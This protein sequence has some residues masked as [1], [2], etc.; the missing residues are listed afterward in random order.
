MNIQKQPFGVARNNTPVDLF[1]LTNDN[2]ITV[3][4]TNYGGIIT[5]I[6]TPDRNG[7]PGDIVLGFDKLVG[8]LGPHP[9]FGALVG[10]NAN[11]TA[12]ARF[13]LDD[14]EY[15]LAQN[16]GPNH[17]HGGLIGFDKV[18]W[19]AAEFA[20]DVGVGVVLTYTS[21]DGEEGYPGNLAAQVTYTLNNQNEL[22]VD[23]AATTDAP[24]VVN[25]TNHSY[26]NLAGSGTILDHVVT[27]NANRYTPVDA[28]LIP[29]GELAPVEGTPMDFRQ[30]TRI[31]E[32]IDQPHEQLQRGG[33][34]DHNW[35]LN[36]LAGEMRHAAT[37]SEPTSGRRM[38]VSTTQPGI[39]FYCGNMMPEQITGKGG[40]VYPRRGGLCLETQNFPDAVNQPTFP[41]PVLRPGERYAQSTLFRFGR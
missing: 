11:R 35:V 25:L 19:Q 20:D 31:G 34:Y 16:N 38:D 10:R 7:Q 15:A 14:V 1:I 32:R 33:G 12:G 36:G 22:R 27:L 4:I 41:S 28:T 3:K 18:V 6:V 2:G 37:V 13:A 24:T 17:L 9:F 39:Q 5:S 29:T 40:N 21:R 8:Y 26:F 23:Y 30:P